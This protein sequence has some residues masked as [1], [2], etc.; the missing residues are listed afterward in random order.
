MRG[1]VTRWSRRQCLWTGA[2]AGA[3]LCGLPTRAQGRGPASQGP[4]TTGPAFPAP[5]LM[6]GD[7]SP[8]SIGVWS[9]AD[10]DL[11][12]RTWRVE[13]VGPGRPIRFNGAVRPQV[14]GAMSLRL[15]DLRA[16][17]GYQVRVVF[18]GPD[19]STEP[20]LATFRAPGDARP[21]R[22]GW[23]GDLCGQGFGID[24]SRGGL[25]VFDT[26]AQEPLDAFVL[27]GDT[28]YADQPI[29]PRKVLPDGTVR[30]QLV[31]PAKAKAA[32]TLEAFRGQYRY[33]WLS[34]SYRRLWG[35]TP[36]VAVWDD[37]E[38]LNN[39]CPDQD[40]QDPRYPGLDRTSELAALGYRA[41]RESLP[42]GSGP[43]RLFRHLP[44]GPYLDLF[45]LDGRSHRG[46]NRI[47]ARGRLLGQ[48][49]LEW[50]TQALRRSR[51]R[52]K[53]VVCDTPL[54][55]VVPDGPGRVDGFAEG[56]PGKPRFRER[57]LAGL[58]AAAR[59]RVEELVV[60]TADVHYAAH[61]LYRPPGLT[62]HE[63]VAGPLH[64]GQFGPQV[65]DPTFGSEVL[66]AN[67]SPGDPQNLAPT[68]Q[69]TSYGVVEAG[70]RGLS[71]ALRDGGGRSLHQV[72]LPT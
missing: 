19:G 48:V 37:H 22:I 44:F 6:L 23:S 51:A 39:W 27:A 45:V 58:Y 36:V 5:P 55:L 62:V 18:D 28:V 64:A 54:G 53:V 67:R 20:A 1:L 72:H 10:L 56:G 14:G 31:T 43:D 60:L 32:D 42:I 13:V 2:V 61:H 25:F 41:L 50:F 47:E 69:T 17:A 3:G 71:V 35:Q 40:L 26:L 66:Y 16:G 34:E 59:A 12:L 65:L 52:W 24:P 33:N 49:Q 8:T 29:E 15:D 21:V 9:Q 46:D 63:F 68:P 7:P 11:D 57:E 70:P 38:V 30:N 4:K